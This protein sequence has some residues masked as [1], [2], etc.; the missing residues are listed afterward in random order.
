MHRDL[1]IP[2]TYTVHTEDMSTSSKNDFKLDF[3][4]VGFFVLTTGNPQGVSIKINSSKNEA[5]PIKGN[6]VHA[7]F[8]KSLYLSYTS[9][10]EAR[11]YIVVQ[12]TGNEFKMLPQFSS[13]DYMREEYE[14]IAGV[15]FAYTVSG[16]LDCRACSVM[17]VN[18]HATIG[19]NYTIESS[20]GMLSL[21]AQTM[22]FDVASTLLNP[23]TAIIVKLDHA[24]RNVRVGYQRVGGLDNPL[25][26]LMLMSHNR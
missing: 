16:Q 26:Y 11:I 19:I 10:K 7:Q 23:L 13:N 14:V 4:G 22:Y 5:I 18:D 2:D 24:V 12:L 25:V 17:V 6:Y 1:V 15:D 8:F 3:Q 20:L 9:S 21:P